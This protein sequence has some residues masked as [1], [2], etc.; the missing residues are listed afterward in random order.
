MSKKAGLKQKLEQTKTELVNFL[1]SLNEKQ[2]ETTVYSEGTT[3]T[4]RDIIT[5]LVDAEPGLSIQIRK[6]RQGK[7]TIPEGF[8]LDK[9]NNAVGKR[10]GNLS[11]VELLQKLDDVRAKTL[12]GLDS[13]EEHEWEL[14]GRHPV[15]GI[16]TIERYYHIIANH[17]Q[18]HLNDI[19]S[20]LASE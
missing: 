8:D 4:V 11:P 10:M 18:T 1:Q 15:E 19:K 12:E 9:W 7:E 2:W 3:W 20:V 14:K 6:I 13:I 16:V 17:Q 5:H